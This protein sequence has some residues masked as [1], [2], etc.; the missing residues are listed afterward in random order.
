LKRA[1]KSERRKGTKKSRTE[2]V[3]SPA[4]EITIDMLT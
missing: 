3:S 4:V 1:A 2:T